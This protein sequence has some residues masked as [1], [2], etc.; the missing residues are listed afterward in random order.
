M[1]YSFTLSSTV[2]LVA[3]LSFSVFMS[4]IASAER[5]T[6]PTYAN[7]CDDTS[8]KLRLS[9]ADVRASELLVELDALIGS[10]ELVQISDMGTCESPKTTGGCLSC[11][12]LGACKI[13]CTEKFGPDA[14]GGSDK[15]RAGC[16][17]GCK[18]KWPKGKDTCTEVH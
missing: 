18:S 13:C 16:Q 12:D 1:K 5:D 8:V 4:T 15:K 6:G 11:A 2:A 9:E 10:T 3:V 7:V 17:N 14:P